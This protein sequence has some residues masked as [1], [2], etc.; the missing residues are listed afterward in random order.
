MVSEF[1]RAKI[2][3]RM[4]RGKL[5]RLRKGEMTGGQPPYGY[6]HICKTSE[7]PATLAPKEPEAST[8]RKL[9]EMFDNGVSLVRLTRWLQLTTFSGSSISGTKL[10]LSARYP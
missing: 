5:H 8:V 9:F 6:G 7:R 2:I 3:E 4:M 1:E 10:P